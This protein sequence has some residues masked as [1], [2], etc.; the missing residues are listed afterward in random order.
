MTQY[1]ASGCFCLFHSLITIVIFSA[2]CFVF[3]VS[4]RQPAATLI[5]SGH[6]NVENR[7]NKLFSVYAEPSTSTTLSS[8]ASS[9]CSLSPSLPCSNFK[10][11][12]LSAAKK[13]LRELAP[14]LLERG[15][16]LQSGSVV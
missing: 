14:L 16:Y 9:L 1:V 13:M 12:S 2:S 8:T 11:S 6:K 15:D 5:A 10:F 3:W 7:T 4:V